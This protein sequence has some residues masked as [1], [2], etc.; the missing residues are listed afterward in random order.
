MAIRHGT[1]SNIKPTSRLI[2]IDDG[3]F[4][5]KTDDEVRYAPLIAVWLK[6]SHLQHLRTDWITVD[7]LDATRK[8]QLLL[9]GSLHIPV[10]LSGVTCG[11]FNLIASWTVRHKTHA[12]VMVRLG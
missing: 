8:V 2:G 6:G 3:P 10:L 5:P 9:K 12:Q 4:P 1:Y 11:G 7:G